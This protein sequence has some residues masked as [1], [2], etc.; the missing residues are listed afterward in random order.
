MK[1]NI[2]DQS[3]VRCWDDVHWKKLCWWI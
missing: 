1:L 2:A 3:V